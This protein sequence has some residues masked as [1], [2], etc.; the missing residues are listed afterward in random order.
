MLTPIDIHYLFGLLTLVSQPD[1]VDVELGY[2]AYDNAA[3]KKRDV[4]VV[5]RYNDESKGKSVLIG[6]EVKKHGRP[7]DVEHVEQLIIK[8]NDM[9]EI[10]TKKIV[11]ASGYTDGAIEKAKKHRIELLILSDW[12]KKLDDFEHI[13]LNDDFIF[14]NKVLSWVNTPKIIYNPSTNS[15]DIL[16]ILKRNPKVYLPHDDSGINNLAELNSFILSK[17][18][19]TL[20][21]DKKFSIPNDYID[22]R[23]KLTL[24]NAP[25]FETTDEKLFLNEALVE[26][27]VRWNEKQLK[28]RYKAIYKYGENKPYVGCAITEMPNGNLLGL[29][30]SQFDRNIN[31]INVN[32]SER[33]KNKIFKRKL[34]RHC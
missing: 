15:T 16:K 32:V 17:A 31:L 4:D 26:G 9:K 22:V 2:M 30:Y 13:K 33:N 12:N 5:L 6:I 10:E 7:L 11:S 21:R 28:P 18:L 3:R 29:T 27:V 8:L 14:I 25:Y 20:I 1:S 34:Q 23:V 19:N 24:K